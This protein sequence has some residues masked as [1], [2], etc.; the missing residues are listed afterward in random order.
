MARFMNASDRQ[1]K[2]RS[3]TTYLRS[4]GHTVLRFTNARV[5]EDTEGLL[6]QIASSSPLYPWER[7]WE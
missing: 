3:A 1:K 2:T 4:L 5:F 6:N 7:G